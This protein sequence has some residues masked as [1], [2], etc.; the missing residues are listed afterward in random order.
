MDEL[1]EIMT[2]EEVAEFLY[3]GKNTIY[4]LLQSGELPAFRIGRTWKIPHSSLE[5][6]ILKKCGAGRTDDK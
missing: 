1:H 3:V 4:A 5:Q 2:V 6:Y